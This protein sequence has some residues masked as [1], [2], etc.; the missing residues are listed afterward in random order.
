MEINVMKTLAVVVVAAVCT[1]LTRVAPFLLFG[2]KKEVPAYVQYLGKILPP[3]IIATLIIY[4][5]K[6]VNLTM[7]PSGIPE[8]ICIGLVVLLHLWKRNNLLSIG[9]G[10]IC[11]MFLVQ[12][13]FM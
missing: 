7:P 13:V 2:G 11:Y 4:C 1:F 12:C 10:T 6:Q 9:A 5:L 3:A 8:F